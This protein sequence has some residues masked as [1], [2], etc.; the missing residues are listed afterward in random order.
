MSYSCLDNITLM[1][2]SITAAYQLHINVCKHSQHVPLGTGRAA[3]V[4]GATSI[5]PGPALVEGWLTANLK[6]KKKVQKIEKKKRKKK[7]PPPPQLKQHSGILITLSLLLPLCRQDT[8][9][10][11]TIQP[12]LHTNKWF[13][14]FL[15]Q[16]AP[17][18][19]PGEHVTDTSLGQPQYLK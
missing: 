10:Q 17:W 12:E 11:L 16:F 1:R 19:W 2:N 6:K 15:G 5:T 9:S 13:S 4:D 8:L 18:L 7:T 14:A 3:R